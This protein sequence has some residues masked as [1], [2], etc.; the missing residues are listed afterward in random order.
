MREINKNVPPPDTYDV[1]RNTDIKSVN[2]KQPCTFGHSFQNY[3]RTCD[4][5]GDIKVYDFSANYSNGAQ[6]YPDVG[7]AKKQAPLFSQSKAKQFALW[8]QEEKQSLVTPGP[9]SYN[10]S[11]NAI[12]AT[13][14]AS[15]SLGL[16]VKGN[17]KRIKL[18]PGPADYEIEGL[19][20][21][22]V[23]K[24]THNWALNHGGVPL[25]DSVAESK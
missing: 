16:D 20:D 6:Y 9:L 5:Q 4:I 23:N 8:E 21:N 13:R 7:I 18:T 17:Q 2:P 3:R 10:Q 14:F 1:K 11:D 15:I 19:G 12:R 25:R 24:K 22:A